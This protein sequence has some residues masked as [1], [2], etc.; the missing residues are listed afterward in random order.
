MKLY[1]A[2]VCHRTPSWVEEGFRE[3]AGRMP[4]EARIE[5]VEIKARRR[6]GEDL[7]RM[8][9]LEAQRIDAA[10]PR[11]AWR[12]AL[13]ER[14]AALSSPDLAGKLSA[15]RET[16]RDVG[17]IIG[18]SDG[19]APRIRESAHFVW[20]LSPLTLPHGLVRILVAEQLYRAHT[21][22]AGHPYHRD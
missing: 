2:A 12:V 6:G 18:G 14:G 5:L 11:S 21:I 8:L 3:Y 17:L 10:L 19:L 7:A 22:L 9:D 15:W 20:S 13:D 4:R 16:G 1:V